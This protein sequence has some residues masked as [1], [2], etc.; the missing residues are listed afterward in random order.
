[1]TQALK[2]CNALIV[3]GMSDREKSEMSNPFTKILQTILLRTT[4]DKD[5]AC[6]ISED[7][8]VIANSS[9]FGYH[10]DRVFFPD[11]ETAEKNVIEV[12]HTGFFSLVRILTWKKQFSMMM[13]LVPFI[14]RCCHFCSM[15]E[16]HMFSLCVFFVY[17][18][19]E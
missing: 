6:G 15:H 2:A 8:T 13:M 11:R 5:D 1:M 4:A 12:T 9:R 19:G 16:T 18:F 14:F 3:N 10:C 7:H 17:Q